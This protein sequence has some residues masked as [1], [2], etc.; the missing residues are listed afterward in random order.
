METETNA[1]A[2]DAKCESCQ[3]NYQRVTC[4]RCGRKLCMFCSH[5]V[6]E[7]IVV[8]GDGCAVVH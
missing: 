7:N 6:N 4:D 1:P 5:A 3:T 8:C 2:W